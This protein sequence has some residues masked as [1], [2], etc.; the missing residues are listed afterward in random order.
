[1]DIKELQRKSYAELQRE[2]AQKREELREL[3]FKLAKDEVKN[4]REARKFKKSIAQ[5]LTI[6]NEKRNLGKKN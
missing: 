4:V 5:I 2:L 1:M 3:R 6:L